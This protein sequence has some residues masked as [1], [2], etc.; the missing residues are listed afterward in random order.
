LVG[1]ISAEFVNSFVEVYGDP[2]MLER[3]SIAGLDTIAKHFS[4]DVTLKFIA[5]DFRSHEQENN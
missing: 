3:H 2:E 1:N 5:E 4:R